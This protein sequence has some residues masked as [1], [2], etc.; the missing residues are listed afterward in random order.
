MKQNKT[1]K[2]LALKNQ[3][4]SK[5]ERRWERFTSQFPRKWFKTKH[6]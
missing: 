3:K 4:N 1:K 6:A 2:D 5:K